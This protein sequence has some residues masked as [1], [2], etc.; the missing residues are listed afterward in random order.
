MN[1]RKYMIQGVVKKNVLYI[2]GILSCRDTQFLANS[3]SLTL[4]VSSWSQEKN[5]KKLNVHIFWNTLYMQKNILDDLFSCSISKRVV[6]FL[7]KDK[8]N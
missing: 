7:L 4:V 1:S 2:S 3:P 5:S 8:V 6:D